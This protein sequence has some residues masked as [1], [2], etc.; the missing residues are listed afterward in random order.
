MMLVRKVTKYN[1]PQEIMDE[2]FDVRMEY[3]KRKVYLLDIMQK[4]NFM[5]Y[6]VKFIRESS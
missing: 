4:V 2:F 3:Y 5:I 1:S 6:R